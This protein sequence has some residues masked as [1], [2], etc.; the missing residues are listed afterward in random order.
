M[1]PA[2][3]RSIVVVWQPAT[4]SRPRPAD[5]LTA[6]RIQKMRHELHRP[7]GAADGAP[8]DSAG[9]SS[10]LGWPGRLPVLVIKPIFHLKRP[11]AGSARG[12]PSG[13]IVSMRRHE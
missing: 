5:G 7:K 8:E 12:A 6:Q 2:A 10:G 1:G 11:V 9:R 3:F 13:A 4:S